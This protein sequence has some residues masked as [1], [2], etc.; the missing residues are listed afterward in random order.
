MIPGRYV[1]ADRIIGATHVEL[2]RSIGSRYRTWSVLVAVGILSAA[3]C[4]RRPDSAD[5]PLLPAKK[6]DSGTKVQE[7]KLVGLVKG[8]DRGAKEVTIRHEEIPGF[9]AAMT[10]PFHVDDPA[11]LEE[12][13]VGD[14]VEGK[15]RVERRGGQ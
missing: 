5:A 9:M 3:G 12:V 14:E 11:T 7:Y 15:L 8:V 4:G 2:G 13:Q 1:W 6:E 10:M